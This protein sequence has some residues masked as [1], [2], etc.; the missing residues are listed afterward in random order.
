MGLPAGLLIFVGFL[1]LGASFI[2]QLIVTLG[3]VAIKGVFFLR[4]DTGV[5]TG[6]AI[7]LIFGVFNQCAT[8]LGT[9]AGSICS[10]A[11]LGYKNSAA[12][13]TGLEQILQQY[14]V[15]DLPYALVLQPISTGFTALAAGA[16]FL[17]L[18]TNTV[19]WPLSAVWASL[20][21]MSA[22]V[23]ELVLFILARN[24]FRDF[25]A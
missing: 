17:H 6:S 4:V 3:V 9:N 11:E 23:I 12:D 18:C 2:L 16:A 5:D 13:I 1:S 21:T 20:L 25:F 19:L 22:L 7:R 15:K 8:P 14:F 24:D 10:A